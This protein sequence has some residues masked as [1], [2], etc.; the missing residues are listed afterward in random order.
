MSE[1]KKQLDQIPKIVDALNQEYGFDD[2]YVI[3]EKQIT[4]HSDTDTSIITQEEKNQIR[5]N[6]EENQTREHTKDKKEVPATQQNKSQSPIT[7]DLFGEYKTIDSPHING[8][9]T[10][11]NHH[12]DKDLLI[13]NTLLNDNKDQNGPIVIDIINKWRNMDTNSFH[14]QYAFIARYFLK[15]L[16][17]LPDK[18]KPIIENVNKLYTKLNEHL[19]FSQTNSGPSDTQ[20]K[21]NN[22]L[23]YAIDTIRDNN[24]NLE[25]IL[26]LLNKP[27]KEN[28][29]TN[30]YIPK[31]HI[32]TII[33]TITMT[34]AILFTF[35][36]LAKY[37]RS[38]LLTIIRNRPE[39]IK[40]DGNYYIEIDSDR[41]VVR[42]IDNNGNEIFYAKI[43]SR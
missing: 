41:K 25:Q 38:I 1:I 30:G 43:K 12:H 17:H 23:N 24:K 37:S 8:A 20:I 6:L 14:F 18:F 10:I 33:L 9:D 27:K 35:Q 11:H 34:V 13:L 31:N 28:Q 4:T 39:I 5:K 15:L 7:D 36:F 29:N 22:S 42:E 26:S 19:Q 32:L 40:H 21:I 3:D 16:Y 2:K